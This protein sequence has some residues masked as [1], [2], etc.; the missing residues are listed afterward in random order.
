MS[1]KFFVVIIAIIVVLVVLVLYVSEHMRRKLTAGT[2]KKM[3]DAMIQ[4]DTDVAGITAPSA[5][6][7]KMQTDFA[8]DKIALLELR[9]KYER[10]A[11]GNVIADGATVQMDWDTTRAHWKLV[12]ELIKQLKKENVAIPAT[13]AA[14]K[15]TP[16]EKTTK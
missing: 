12:R 13:L 14:R 10:D 11:E 7:A 5:D 2:M 16:A 9:K 3:I 4:Q 6:V 8:K 1:L 15:M